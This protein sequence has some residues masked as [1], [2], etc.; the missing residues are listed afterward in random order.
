VDKSCNELDKAYEEIEE[1][2]PDLVSRAL[3]W[4]RSP[5]SRWVRIPLGALCIIGSL[6]WWL[7]V[8]GLEL[9]PIGLLL[10]AQDVPFLCK[11]AAR[12]TLWL[13]AQWRKLKRRWR[14]GRGRHRHQPQPQRR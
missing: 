13:D 6:F 11:P 14:Q 3:E 4:L 5:R 8:L 2:L 10:L 9:L 1:D 12:F 7:P